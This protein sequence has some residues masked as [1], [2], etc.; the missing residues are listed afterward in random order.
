MSHPKLKMA[1]ASIYRIV[2]GLKEV[3]NIKGLARCSPRGYKELDTTGQLNN[4][5]NIK[6]LNQCL[7][8][9]R[10][11][12]GISMVVATEF[13]QEWDGWVSQR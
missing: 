9:S 4:N 13:S 10:C 3:N 7:A 2:T 5:N 8:H 1:I 6:D 12:T 11:C